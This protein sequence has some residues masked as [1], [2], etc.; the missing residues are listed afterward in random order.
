M[1]LA[2]RPLDVGERRDLCTVALTGDD[3]RADE[4]EAQ[5]MAAGDRAA[6]N[7]G[8]RQDACPDGDVCPD[9]ALHSRPDAGGLS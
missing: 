4:L 3:A 1:I 2:D 8:L 6:A 5:H 7:A 9:A